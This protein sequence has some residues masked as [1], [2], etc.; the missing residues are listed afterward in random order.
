M[1][2]KQTDSPKID[3]DLGRYELRRAGRPQSLARK[4]MD[5]LIY[6][7]SRP[8]QLVTR[9]EII[10]HLW[11][12]DLF[13]DA[14]SAVN[15]LVRKIRAALGDDAEKPRFLQTVVGKGYRF[16]G[17]INVIQP[18]PIPAPSVRQGSA[19]P[20]DSGRTSL[21]VLPFAIVGN[22]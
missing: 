4:P 3:L 8:E 12:S 7:A 16:V 5:F 19:A 13:L 1:R 6:L 9:E 15:N 2:R 10:R 18:Q 22:S 21:A 20:L 17:A 11:R 14:D